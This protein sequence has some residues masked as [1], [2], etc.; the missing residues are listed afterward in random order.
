MDKVGR[1]SIIKLLSAA[2]VTLR[3]PWN[4]LENGSVIIILSDILEQ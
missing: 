3:S 2:V 1:V 4:Q